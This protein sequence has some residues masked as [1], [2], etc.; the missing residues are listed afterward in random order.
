MNIRNNFSQSIDYFFFG[1]SFFLYQEYRIITSDGS[2]Y[3]RNITVIYVVGDTAGVAWSCF[4]NNHVAREVDRLES[5]THHH[6][7]NR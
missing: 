1:S 6:F 3:L 2:Q 5:C 7:G 4:D